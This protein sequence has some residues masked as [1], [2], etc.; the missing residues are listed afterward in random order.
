MKRLTG[1]RRYPSLIRRLL[2]RRV[3]R[4]PPRFTWGL[5]RMMAGEKLTLLNGRLYV[6]THFTPMPSGAFDTALESMVA[7][8][9][10][11]A[12]PIS[13]YISL[14]DRCRFTCAYCSNAKEEPAADR[15]T[16]E[17]RDAVRQL[18]EAGA[19]CIGFTG[20]EPMLR[21]DLAEI[22][23]TV[24]RRSYSVLF[25]SG[26]RVDDAAA[27]RLAQAGLTVAAVSLDSRRAEEQ[28]R[29][30]GS[31]AAFDTAVR[32]I[33]AFSGAGVYTSVSAVLSP[34]MASGSDKL[35]LVRF[36]GGLGAHEV[37]F[38]E[39]IPSGRLAGTERLIGAGERREMERFR[40]AVNRDP[41]LP[42]VAMLSRMESAECFGCGA[43]WFHV[44]VDAAGRVCPCD[45]V[46]VPFGKIG[47]EPFAAVYRRMRDAVPPFATTCLQSRQRADGTFLAGEGAPPTL[48]AALA[49]LAA[50]GEPE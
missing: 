28:N 32:A 35:D 37:R 17:A 30:R 13:A 39:P 15:T 38:L 34:R 47:E 49:G 21:E 44:Y 2:D 16:V 5:L 12:R 11:D 46:Q 26:H 14:T 29:V 27:A 41:S 24:D 33:R 4:L 36:C 45:F 40:R 25:T 9:R 19:C 31:G 43:G 48:L 22:V 7:I 42:T 6:T 20:G 3:L 10:G 8:S 23:A 18:Q 1:W 50:T